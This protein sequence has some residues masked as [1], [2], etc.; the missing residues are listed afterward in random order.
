MYTLSRASLRVHLP[1]TVCTYFDNYSGAI[2]HDCDLA[3]HFRFGRVPT[4]H[5][6]G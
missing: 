1:L 6:W 2:Q 3:L 4:P 5:D